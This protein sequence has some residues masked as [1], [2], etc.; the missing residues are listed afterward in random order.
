VVSEQAI[1]RAA[2]DRDAPAMKAALIA[3]GYLPAARADVVDAETALRL[4]RTAIKW[5]AAPGWRRFSPHGAGRPPRPDAPDPARRAA[6]K[7]QVDQFTLPPDAVLLRR[8]HGIVAVV[9]QQLHAGGDWGAIAAE[10]LHGAPPA[11]PLGEAEAAF[12]NA[13]AEGVS[14]R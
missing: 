12:L 6:I 4:M 9:L 10:Y 2:R 8:M 7:D 3:G 5:Y 11:S 1:A 13:R 14:P